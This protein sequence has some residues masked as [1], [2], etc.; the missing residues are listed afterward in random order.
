[1]AMVH[2]CERDCLIVVC[3][4][5]FWRGKLI[6]GAREERGLWREVWRR[7]ASGP[8]DMLGGVSW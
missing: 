4:G 2:V 7:E 8:A 6:N 5:A 1:M 3:E